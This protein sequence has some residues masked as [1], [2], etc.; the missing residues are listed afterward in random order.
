M[1]EYEKMMRYAGP[2]SKYEK[3]AA[4]DDHLRDVGGGGYDESHTPAPSAM[5]DKES[6]LANH[7]PTPVAADVEPA[8]E[9]PSLF[10]QPPAVVS[11]RINQNFHDRRG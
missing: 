9:Q 4:R 2:Q 11:Q 10:D 6:Y 8:S 5:P 1:G 3:M 7:G